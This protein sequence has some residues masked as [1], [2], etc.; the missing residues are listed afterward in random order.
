M[1]NLPDLP[2]IKKAREADFGVEFRKWITKKKPHMSTFELK[3]TQTDSLPF[4]SVEQ[5]QLD[6]AKAIK[7]DEGALIRV[8]GTSGEPDY[9]WCKKT[10]AYIMVRYPDCFCMIHAGTFASESI[11]SQRRSLTSQRAKEI[12][13]LVVAKR[14]TY[15]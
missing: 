9:V 8:Q 2:N 4:A 14:P 5:S 13:E 15:Q 6:W 1:N 12:A 7:S 11:M 10:P 3:Q